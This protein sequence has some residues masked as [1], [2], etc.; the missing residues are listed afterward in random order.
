MNIKKALTLLE[1]G[2]IICRESQWAMVEAGFAWA[3]WICM[4][5][6]YTEDD[7]ERYKK[8]D[9]PVP[10]IEA[11][12]PYKIAHNTLCEVTFID[13]FDEWFKVGTDWIDVTERFDHGF[14]IGY[15]EY[16]ERSNMEQ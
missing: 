3:P 10:P 13:S 11:S 16:L 8:G 6:I 7:I 4:K 12:G 9:W 15:R 14:P 1:N 2:H 5:R